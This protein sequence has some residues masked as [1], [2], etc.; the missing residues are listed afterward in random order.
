MPTFVFEESSEPHTGAPRRCGW[1]LMG[2]TLVPEPESGLCRREGN[3]VPL[4]SF[5][6]T[7]DR[8]TFALSTI[9]LIIRV[10]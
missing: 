10:T 1:Q 8:I 7:S 4:K 5:R 6:E 2:S 9:T 3:E